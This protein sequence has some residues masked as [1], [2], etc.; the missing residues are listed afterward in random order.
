[1]A[2]FSRRTILAAA[3]LLADRI[4]SEIDRFALEH[5]LEAVAIGASKADKTNALGRYLIQ[6]PSLNNEYGENLSDAVVMAILGRAIE[7]SFRGYPAEFSFVDFQNQF[8]ALNRGLE[9]DGF[10]V[11][12]GVLR[13]ILPDFVDL[14]AADDEVHLLLE[15]FGLA[16]PAGHLDQ[17]ISAHVRGQ[18]AAANAQ[19][20]T[21]IESLLDEIALRAPAPAGGHP[22][23]GHARRQ[24]L[25]NVTPPFFIA[26]L[27]EWSHDGRGFFEALFR[28]LHPE[29][30][31]PG[32]SDEEDSTFRFHLVL[33]TGRHLLRRLQTMIGQP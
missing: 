23:T 11:E 30:S 22:P 12:D 14:P 20:R 9:R 27:N 8:P 4:H 17:G 7:R 29:G 5:G 18:W 24:W 21:F 25:A 1:M 10:T 32:L 33:L 16:V 15:R 26:A 28:R 13:R 31:H 2:Q 19:F 6:N 3:D